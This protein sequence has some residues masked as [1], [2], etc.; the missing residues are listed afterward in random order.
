MLYYSILLR[1]STFVAVNS[2]VIKVFIN[3]PLKAPK[4]ATDLN[5]YSSLYSDGFSLEEITLMRHGICRFRID[6]E[7]ENILVLDS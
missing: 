6:S 4:I 3:F 7:K 1:C 5:F 2:S